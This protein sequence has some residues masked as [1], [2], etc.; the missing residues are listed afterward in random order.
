M[1]GSTR[2]QE[3]CRPYIRVCAPSLSS[4][5]AP[6]IYSLRRTDVA[7]GKLANFGGKQKTIGKG[8]KIKS[9]KKGK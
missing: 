6:R 7:K 1:T 8:G 9:K 5:R 3:T 2:A 4:I